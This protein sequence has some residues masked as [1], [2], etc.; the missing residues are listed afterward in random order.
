MLNPILLI[1][2]AAITSA[3][4]VTVTVDRLSNTPLLAPQSG[5]P[6]E[7]MSAGVFN[8]AA[9]RSH[10]KTVL[11]FRAQD[12]KHTS[13]IGY[14]DSSDG[15]RFAVRQQPVLV[16]EA[17]YER[18]GGL[19]DPRVVKIE[20][21]YY[22]TYTGYDLH[23]AQLCLATSKDL[24][25]WQRKGIILPAYK[26]TWNEQWTKSGAIVPVQID[27][28]WWMYYLGTRKDVDGKARDFMGLA[29]SPD[30]LHWRDATAQPVLTRRPNAFDSRVMEPG[31][32]PF[33]TDRGILLLYNGADEKLV[34]RLGWVLFDRQ[35]PD[36]VLA[37][38][39][40]P[41][42]EPKF[43]WEKV[44]NVPN[45]VFVEG[46]VGTPA[47]GVAYYGAADKYLGGMRVRVSIH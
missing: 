18:G 34:Y 9:I 12:G 30:L 35:H 44:G 15:I 4:S 21:D 3:Q 8:P 13:R 22:L 32:A 33:V 23:N 38:S 45:V 5:P 11:L 31:P 42:A 20:G 36:H 7:W 47:D 2:A 14:A 6:F 29:V 10:E 28:K 43:Q 1:T 19:E 40:Q 17:P 37:R 46:I 25:H 16:P 26:G 24:I 39:E 41:V 27:G